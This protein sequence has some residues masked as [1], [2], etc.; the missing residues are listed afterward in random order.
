MTLNIIGR[1]A[2]GVEIN[3]FEDE[4][5]PFLT[6]SKKMFSTRFNDPAVYF[7]SK[8]GSIVV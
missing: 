5:N 6:Y 3:A 7:M 4:K 2:F 1:S 8:F